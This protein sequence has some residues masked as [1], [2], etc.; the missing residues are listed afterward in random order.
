MKKK[1]KEIKHQQGKKNSQYGTIWIHKDNTVKKIKKEEKEKYLN[2]GW[3][4]GR[5]EKQIKEKKIPAYKTIDEKKAFLLH[6]QGYS[7]RI[8]AKQ[9]GV[10]VHVMEKFLRWKRGFI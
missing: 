10:T 3:K 6:K 2:L 9:L 5:K 8:V 7:W 1:F 4:T